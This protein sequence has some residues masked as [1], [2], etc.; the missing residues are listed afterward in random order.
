M[1]KVVKQI[2]DNYQE[3]C[4]LIEGRKNVPYSPIVL[5]GIKKNHADFRDKVVSILHKK[6]NKQLDF[7]IE[8]DK[9]DEKRFHFNVKC[10]DLC[11]EP[12][13]RYDSI[14]PTH[15]NSNLN[16]PIN[17]QEILT[18]HFHKY[19]SDGKEIAYKTDVLKNP[20]QEKALQDITLCIAHFCTEAKIYYNKSY[21]EVNPNPDTFQFQGVI[22]EDPLLNVKFE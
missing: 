19:T 3:Y 16:I 11:G 22:D 10:K 6:L 2:K 17:E 15:R 18:P 14:G 21:P 4:E 13:F 1:Q 5:D 8:I 9:Y 7:E 20:K 12:I